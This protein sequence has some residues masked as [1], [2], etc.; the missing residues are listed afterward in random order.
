[1]TSQN[2]MD[3]NK[4]ERLG[5]LIRDIN[6]QHRK[7]VQNALVEIG[8]H[9]S[10]PRILFT[11]KELKDASQKEIADHL[12]VS[13]ASLA[14]S[15]KR[16]QKAGFL[17][18]KIDETDQ[19]INKIS[20]TEKGSQV[21]EICRQIIHDIDRQM[22]DS[23]TEAEQDLLFSLLHKVSSNLSG[24]TLEVAHMAPGSD[25]EIHQQSRHR[26]EP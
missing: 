18:R 21:I 3:H 1:M 19:R 13:P 6:H 9:H 4:I 7:L 14:I 2:K 22:Q 11:V 15:L 25:D 24:I 17:A 23:L 10:Q 12:K 8:L 20:L 16:M 26:G 5:F